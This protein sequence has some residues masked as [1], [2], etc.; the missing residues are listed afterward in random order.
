MRAAGSNY[1]TGKAVI[2]Y[3]ECLASRDVL[4]RNADKLCRC[5][6]PFDD[7]VLPTLLLAGPGRATDGVRGQLKPDLPVVSAFQSLGAT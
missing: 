4:G 5:V 1:L 3:A 2:C 6:V 7:A